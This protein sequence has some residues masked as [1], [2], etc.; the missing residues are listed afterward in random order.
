MKKRIRRVA[1]TA[2]LFCATGAIYALCVILIG[3]G[4]PCI[5]HEVT[6]L[7]C[8]GCG[9]TRFATEMIKLNFSSALNSNYAAPIIVLFIAWTFIYTSAVYIRTGRLRVSAGNT[10]AEI[11]FLVFLII[12]TI[13]RNVAGI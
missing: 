12:W 11:I 2:A 3:R 8:P 5:F 6:G 10:A 1:F 13:G 7:R 9:I 4:I